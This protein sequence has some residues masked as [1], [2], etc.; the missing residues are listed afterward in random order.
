MGELFGRKRKKSKTPKKKKKSKT[1]KKRNKSKT[2]KK[3]TKIPQRFKKASGWDDDDYMSGMV[4]AYGKKTEPTP[5]KRII[6]QPSIKRKRN[7]L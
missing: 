5:V 7:F 3:K 4:K 1:P 2:P 6:R